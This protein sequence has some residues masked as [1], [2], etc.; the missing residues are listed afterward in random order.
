MIGA[1]VTGSS[2]TYSNAET[3]G[4]RLLKHTIGPWLARIESAV[5]P[6][7]QPARAPPA[8]RRVLAGCAPRDGHDLAVRL[9]QDGARGRLAHPR[10]DP[11]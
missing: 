2:L 3:E 9:L 1:N 4:L 5:L 11:P 10:G 7:H 6:V 8:V